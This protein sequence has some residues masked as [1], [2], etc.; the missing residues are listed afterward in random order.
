[1]NVNLEA[2][3]S[4]N[5]DDRRSVDSRVKSIHG[6]CWGGVHDF[7]A[8]IQAASHHQVYQ[9]IRPTPH[10][11]IQ[12]PLCSSILCSTK[13][14]T[15]F[16]TCRTLSNPSLP[17]CYV[18]VG[19][20][21]EGR[22]VTDKEVISADVE[23]CRQSLPQLA[24]LWVRVDV[25]VWHR[26][27]GFPDLRGRAIGVLVG[28]QLDDLLRSPPQPAPISSHCTECTLTQ[29]NYRQSTRP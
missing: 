16:P 26:A 23:F 19:G 13:I 15:S 21:G 22:G 2:L 3:Q 10:L 9:L 1:L 17:I 8:W 5:G 7:V 6:K 20:R 12:S 25:G 4:G 24:G 11:Q 18:K 27:Q 28:I 29:G 14:A